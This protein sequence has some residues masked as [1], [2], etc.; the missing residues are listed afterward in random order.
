[1]KIDGKSIF[2]DTSAFILFLHNSCNDITKE[3]F[4]KTL[5]GKYDTPPAKAGGFSPLYGSE[6]SPP[7]T[8]GGACL[9]PLRGGSKP[10][11]M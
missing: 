2:V 6:L 11:P 4:K 7:Q 9:S 3:I 5:E 1:M 8:G 10:T